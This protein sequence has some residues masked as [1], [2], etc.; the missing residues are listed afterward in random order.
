MNEVNIMGDME[1]GYQDAFV[2]VKEVNFND[3]IQ[4]DES[5]KNKRREEKQAKKEREAYERHM[6]DILTSRKKVPPP[7]VLHDRDGGKTKDIKIE[8]FTMNVGGRNLLE[9]ASLMLYEG[10]KY[11]LIGRNGIG[12]T[13]LMNLL[14]SKEIDKFPKYVHIGLVEQEI[15]GESKTVLQSVLDTD[16]EREELLREEQELIK[17][18]SQNTERLNAV[19]QRMQDIDASSA[20]A[21]ASQILAGLGFTK[22]TMA[23]QT[24]SLSGGWRMRVALAR[25][26]FAK[27]DV[28][29]LDEPTN[30]LDLDAVMWLEDY[31]LNYPNTVIV[32]SHAREFLNVVC[33]D[34]I[35]FFESKLTYYKGNYDAFEKA[36]SEK[37]SNMRKAKEAQKAKIEHMQDFIDKF[38]FNAKRASLV[39]SRIKALQKMDNIEDIIEDPTC[40]FIFPTPD[41]LRPPLLKIDDGLFGYSK[42]RI[43]LRNLNIGIDMES[44]VAILGAN[45]VG[46]S[47]FLKLL[48]GEL[49]LIEGNLYRNHRLRISMFT[50]HHIDTLDLMLSPLEQFIKLFPGSSVESYRAHLG[51]FGVSGNLAL[52]PMYLLSGGQKSRVAFAI[53]VWSNPHILILDEPTNHLDLEAVNALIVALNN[54]QGGILVVSHDQHFVASVCDNIWYIK[55]ERLKKFNGDFDDYKRALVLNKL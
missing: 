19:Y 3:E 9:E 39:Q 31:L 17:S 37:L 27:P 20:E 25:V 41:K 34:I 38:R 40:V 1:G 18:D 55:D 35:H 23:F 54:F 14:A 4:K 51:S 24:K 22:D 5:Q 29:L 8:R 53:V 46:K 2:G 33:T 42:E 16:V 50:Q 45:G 21:R 10:R 52:R 28:L 15:Y 26:L 43:L 12:K 30:H 48:L 44:R 47:T 32:V 11:G 6:T 7:Q 36:R 49:S 13:C